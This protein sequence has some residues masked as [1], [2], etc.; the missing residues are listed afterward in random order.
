MRQF[1]VVLYSNYWLPPQRP[2]EDD[3]VTTGDARPL[4]ST[5][6]DCSQLNAGRVNGAAAIWLR[7]DQLLGRTSGGGMLLMITSC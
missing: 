6:P 7:P 1:S 2:R 3:C 4:G 5:R